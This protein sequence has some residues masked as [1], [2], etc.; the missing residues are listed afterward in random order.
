MTKPEP[1][2]LQ[3]I[4]E[5]V[6]GKLTGD[7]SLPVTD[8]T[9]DS[10]QAGPGSLFVAIRGGL[11]DAHKFLPQV[12]A[13]G[14]VGVISELTPT[15]EILQGADL[16][17]TAWIQVENVRRAM[18]L[19]AAEIHHHPS[20]EL[21]LV[22]ITG[23][24]GKTTTA[25]L[26]ASI[27]EA[28]GEPVAMTGTVEYRLGAERRKAERTTPEATDMQR[29][30]RRAVEIGCRTAVMEASSQAMDFH[31]CDELEYSVAVFSNLTRDHLDYHKTM[32][33]Y[34]YAKQRLF[35]GRLG[36]KPKTSVINMDDPYGVELAE[37]LESDGLRVV[38]Y[39]VKADADIT[40]RNAEFSLNG[41]EFNLNTPEGTREFHSPLVGPPHIYN[42]LAA[43]ASG[44]ALGYDLDVITQAL[45]TCT[46][47][48]GRFERVPHDGDFAVVVD[49]AHSDDALLNVL[50]TARDVT[51][52]KIITVFGCGGDRD[53]S[54]RA[55]MGEAAG[56]LSDVVILTS[57]NPRTEDPEKILSDAEA[58]IVKTGKAYRKIADR[59]EAIHQAIFEA[60]SDDLVL[61]AG[62]GHED[63][64][65]LGREV[66]HFDDKEVAREAL[67]QKANS[68]E[69]GA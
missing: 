45:Q 66:F 30:L 34:W 42:T 12:I 37:R 41:M 15:R 36:T 21:Q 64:Q 31:R 28:A 11:F 22:G 48:P 24:N 69:Q 29:M 17:S 33:N 68:S 59:R 43:V 50:R 53:P 32:E 18:A 57:D 65:I 13:K 46:G 1:I 25:Y 58:G 47:A 63:Y 2:T 19:A 16:G 55:P 49:Y 62:K 44:L 56:S 67:A 52:G 7:G 54:K 61:I 20:H 35:D 38:R 26:V 39:A 9:H 4:A 14:A 3:R 40:A 10:R 6:N 8:A 23:T 60:N 27:P 51:K 5:V